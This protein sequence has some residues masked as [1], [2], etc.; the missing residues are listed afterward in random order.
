MNPRAAGVPSGGV[1]NRAGRGLMVVKTHMRCP[2][3]FQFA[4]VRQVPG[5]NAGH[6]SF[7]G[8]QHVG[9]R[10]AVRNDWNVTAAAAASCGI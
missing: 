6:L 4:I 1:D 5:L 10:A 3:A 9:F 8:R 2:G 7:S